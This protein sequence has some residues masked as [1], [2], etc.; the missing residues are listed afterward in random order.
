MINVKQSNFEQELA[1][2]NQ[3]GSICYTEFNSY[4]HEK[5]IVFISTYFIRYFGS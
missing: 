4:Y 2:V 1:L 3:T 5:K